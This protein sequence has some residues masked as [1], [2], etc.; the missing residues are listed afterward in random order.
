MSGFRELPTQRGDDQHIGESTTAIRYN[1]RR[2]EGVTRPP[3]NEQRVVL[4]RSAMLERLRKEDIL[5]LR[6]LDIRTVVDLRTVGER[7]LRPGEAEHL[8]PVTPIPFGSVSSR[9]GAVDP[10]R[11]VV[12]AVFRCPA[13]N[14]DR[15]IAQ[16]HAVTVSRLVNRYEGALLKGANVIMQVSQHIDDPAHLPTLIHCESGKD[17][18]GL[19]VA[20]LMLESG[21]AVD[22]IVEE[23]AVGQAGWIRGALKRHASTTQQPTMA[24]SDL[25]QFFVVTASTALRKVLE[26]GT[27]WTEASRGA[28][29]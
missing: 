28:R 5:Y 21:V 2:V 25:E 14:R 6:S 15:F 3:R 26:S 19:V 24:A 27:T 22:E 20:M 18:T 7:E 12:D 23:F 16:L 4:Y 1:L 11:A 29:S 10:I 8:A 13:V 17:R 9:S